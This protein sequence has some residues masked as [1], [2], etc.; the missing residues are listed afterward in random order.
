MDGNVEQRFHERSTTNTMGNPVIRE[1]DSFGMPWD[2]LPDGRVVASEDFS[3]RLTIWNADGT[4]DRVVTRDYEAM[5][6]S[7]DEIEAARKRLAARVVI[8]G[9]GGRIEPTIEVEDKERDI[10]DVVVTEGGHI[11]VLSSR[12]RMEAPDDAC[13]VYD[14]FDA[15]GHFLQQVVLDVDADLDED[16]LVFAGDR[17]FVIKEFEAA[18]RAQNAMGADEESEEEADEE[19]EPISVVC[20]RFEWQPQAVATPSR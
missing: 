20:Y 3:Y 7:G 9:R 15:E 16:R 12:G 8:R 4:P 11:W 2:I 1:T 6:R 10:Q 5:R 13:A 14:V 17:I 18:A 19:A